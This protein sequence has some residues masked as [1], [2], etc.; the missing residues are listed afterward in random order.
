MR[1]TGRSLFQYAPLLYRIALSAFLQLDNKLV[2]APV[3]DAKAFGKYIAK[4]MTLRAEQND[5]ERGLL[6]V[7]EKVKA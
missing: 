6:S 5:I 3:T 4:G 2:R 7:R 1:A